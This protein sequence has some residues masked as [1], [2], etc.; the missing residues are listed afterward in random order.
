MGFFIIAAY[1]FLDKKEGVIKAYAVTPSPVW[2]YLLSKS[3]GSDNDDAADLPCDH[4]AAYGYAYQ[5]FDTARFSD[6]C[7]TVRLWGWA[8]WWPD[9][10]TVWSNH[11]GSC[12]CL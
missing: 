11:L 12:I 4:R 9:I 3:H 10:L 1:I 6:T 7:G 5:L 8:F 2:K